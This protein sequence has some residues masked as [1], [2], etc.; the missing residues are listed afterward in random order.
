MPDSAVL[1]RGPSPAAADLA[2]L[3][4][5]HEAPVYDAALVPD[6]QRYVVLCDKIGGKPIFQGTGRD[7]RIVKVLAAHNK[8]DV[9]SAEDLGGKAEVCRLLMRHKPFLRAA[10]AFEATQRQVTLEDNPRAAVI[11]ELLAEERRKT[12]IAQ[13]QLDQA[14]AEYAQL[15]G[16]LAG[17]RGTNQQ[18]TDQLIGQLN[19]NVEDLRRQNEALLDQAGKMAAELEAARSKAE[20][21]GGTVPSKG[22]SG[23][24]RR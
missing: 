19:A 21:G 15:Q 3:M 5:D 10:T 17:Q 18:A 23:Q 22:N 9:V 13:A 6:G 4:I 20:Q 1:D 24:P 2:M 7:Q 11:D 8:G 14:G 12:A 16:L